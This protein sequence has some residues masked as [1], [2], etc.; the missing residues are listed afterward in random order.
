[1]YARLTT[2]T[3]I[4][5]P[6][7]VVRVRRAKVVKNPPACDVEWDLAFEWGDHEA[8]PVAHLWHLLRVRRLY[9][10]SGAIFK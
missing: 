10:I 6:E 7:E 2:T 4:R 1:M 8:A 9:I 5:T 3:K